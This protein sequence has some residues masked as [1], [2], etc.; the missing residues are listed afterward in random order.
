[1]VITKHP[2]YTKQLPRWERIAEHLDAA[3]VVD[4]LE[5]YVHRW[6]QGESPGE[7][8]YRLRITKYVPHFSFAIN[9][10][11]GM[12]WQAEQRQA[13]TWGDEG[14][15]TALGTPDES[16]TVMERLWKD[17][18][19]SGTNWPV[20]W[21]RLAPKLVAMGHYYVLADAPTDERPLPS[22][23]LISPAD[24]IDWTIRR[25]QLVE[26][27]VRETVETREGIGQGSSPVTQYVHYTL[28][29][30]QRYEEGGLPIGEPGEYSYYAGPAADSERILPLA[31]IEV[32]ISQALGYVMARMAETL[33]QQQSMRDVLLVIA[34][35]PRQRFGDQQAME[36]AK[37]N[38][39]EGFNAVWGEFEYVAPPSEPIETAGKALAD[40]LKAFFHTFFQSYAEE[41]RQA[42]AT[43][44]LQD[45]ARGPEAYLT[46]LAAAVAEAQNHALRIWEQAVAPSN[47]SLWGHASVEAASSFKPFDAASLADRLLEK[48]VASG[49]PVG[50]T[51]RKHAVKRA[52]DLDGIPHEDTEIDEELA[53]FEAKPAQPLEPGGPAGVLTPRER[54]RNADALDE[55]QARLRVASRTGAIASGD[56]R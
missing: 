34:N 13:E 55:L 45:V 39:A 43:E 28:D 24:V 40:D 35:K 51:A 15:Q 19:G 27:L 36:I 20:L 4:G 32:P 6:E 5:R 54:R 50:T 21:R 56:G 9:A 47:R 52:L 49:A 11:A 48:Y 41:G 53:E 8:E 46:L 16:D 26:A 23:S 25:G 7:Y 29:G 14:A 42:T 17:V 18:D 30:W 44:V 33:L 12:L 10:L 3:A 1:M 31:R 2:T 22:V 37:K 38:L